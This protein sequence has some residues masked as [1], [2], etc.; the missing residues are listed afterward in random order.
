MDP[1]FEMEIFSD[2]GSDDPVFLSD[3]TICN[4]IVPVLDDTKIPF[5]IKKE[6]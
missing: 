4:T 6:V 2:N 3:A 1:E 5:V